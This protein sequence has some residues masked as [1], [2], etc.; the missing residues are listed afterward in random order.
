MIFLLQHHK[1]LV[2]IFFCLM[3]LSSTARSEIS[4]KFASFSHS[5]AAPVKQF[6]NNLEGPAMRS[7]NYAF[8]HTQAEIEKKWKNVSFGVFNRYDHFLEFNND[9]AYLVHADKNKLPV[10][11]NK[12]FD[13]YLKANH[14][15][16]KGIHLS[17]LLNI[18][19]KINTKLRINYLR[20]DKMTDGELK[21]TLTTNED[22]YIGNLYLDYGYSK[23]HLL[24]REEESVLGEGYSLDV[25][26][27]WDLSRNL[28]VYIQGRDIFSKIYWDKLTYTEAKANTN[29][30]SYGPGGVL[31]SIPTVSGFE[32]YRQQI[33]RLPPRY[34]LLAN[35]QFDKNMAVIP[36]AFTYDDYLFPR[37]A[38][39][40]KTNNV[41]IQTSYNFKS[42]SVGLQLNNSWLNLGLELDDLKW[43]KSNTIAFSFKVLVP[44]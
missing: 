22:D 33:Q 30:I 38:I 18:T 13:V 44:I 39:Q 31:N 23:D 27:E 3:N 8:T 7:G 19:P 16:S 15:H 24:K 21:G 37:L 36:G 17:Y 26:L 4:F 12:T 29:T 10:Q 34:Q 11:T 41:S 20:A 14:I 28:S 42:K 40:W 25:D 6:F 9:T 2:I 5:Q 32:G 43:E 35:Y 1:K